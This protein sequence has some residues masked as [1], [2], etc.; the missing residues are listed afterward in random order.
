GTVLQFDLTT[1]II[2]SAAFAIGYTMLGG[3]LA[4]A[5]T[6]VIQLLFILV[7]LCL[8]IPFALD[9]T[10]GIGAV[11]SQYSSQYDSLSVPFP[12]SAMG[13]GIWVWLDFAFLL[14]LGG[15]PWQVYFQ[16]V[17]ACKNERSAMEMSLVAAFGCIVLAIPAIIIGAI[18]ATANWAE[19]GVSPPEAAQVLPYVLQYLTPPFIATLGLG[20][21]AAAVMSS[22]DSS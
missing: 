22:V 20:A 10:G 21:V 9:Y 7:G 17:L 4:V 11:I 2:V 12:T 6:D 18:G 8:A 19:A 15:I 14:M 16:R 3:L 1:S 5:Y 13:Q